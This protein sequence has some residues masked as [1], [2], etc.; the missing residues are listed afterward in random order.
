MELYHHGI[1]GQKWGVQN[2]P[3]YPL[4]AEV[5]TYH[6]NKDG[7]ITISKGAIMQRLVDENSDAAK[8][9]KLYPGM[10]YASFTANDNA[11]Y[12]MQTKE[13][14]AF[15]DMNRNA[16]LTLEVK[17]DLH[18]PSTGEASR[19]WFQMLKDN[20]SYAKRAGE[21]YRAERRAYSVKEL[22]NLIRQSE[23]NVLTQDY[24]NANFV[25]TFYDN[26][27]DDIKESYF[28]E[29]KKAGYNMLRD[30]NDR[31]QGVTKNPVI[32]LDSAN[33]L[34]IKSISHV[35][36]AMRQRASDYYKKYGKDGKDF[37]R[38]LGF[39]IPPS[40]E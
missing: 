1:P 17:K 13:G 29:V 30:E 18:C 39:P 37:L 34:S 22:D 6:I 11:K 7:S 26:G 40:L 21:A 20:P 12:I 24:R 38:Y 3:P 27:F 23:R 8:K 14:G 25:L 33:T 32:V 35:D 10:N 19:I 28:R 2:G 9:K 5:G 31:S 4:G 16:L 15:G 36:D